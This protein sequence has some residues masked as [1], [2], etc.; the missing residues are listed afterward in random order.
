MLPVLEVLMVK[1]WRKSQVE[2]RRHVITKGGCRNCPLQLQ[3]NSEGWRGWGRCRM[4][5]TGVG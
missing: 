3:V 1:V 2:R 4:G 5:D